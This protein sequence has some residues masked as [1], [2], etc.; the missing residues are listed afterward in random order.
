MVEEEQT[1]PSWGMVVF[2][3][4]SGNPGKLFGSQLEQNGHFISLRI[5]RAFRKS[6]HGRD[7]YRGGE[8]IVDVWLSAAQFAEL[9][10]T[11]NVGDGVPC[12]LRQVNREE[13]PR[14]PEDEKTEQDRVRNE[15]V[16]R[17][18]EVNRDII[19]CVKDAT[20][21]LNKPT[22]GK[23]DRKTLATLLSRITCELEHNQPF[24]VSCFQEAAEKVVVHAKAEVDA[25]VTHVVTTAGVAALRLQAADDKLDTAP[26][27]VIA[28]GDL[29]T[30]DAGKA[31]K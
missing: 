26:E 11:M 25:L 18:I 27:R 23:A 4:T 9:L 21:M 22:I 7:W 19:Q 29:T 2:N 3:R 28:S 10:T 31:D 8:T 1:H 24:Y 30:L 16:K 14:M 15:F 17:T 20:E 12:T 5:K 13:M 6:G